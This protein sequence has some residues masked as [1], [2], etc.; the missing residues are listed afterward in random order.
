[1]IWRGDAGWRVVIAIPRFCM[2][3]SA[4]DPASMPAPDIASD[5]PRDLASVSDSPTAVPIPGTKSRAMPAPISTAP[6]TALDICC[7]FWAPGW[8]LLA[9][10]NSHSPRTLN[11]CDWS[12]HKTRFRRGYQLCAGEVDDTCDEVP[13]IVEND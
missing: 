7:S 5:V 3:V 13:T 4:T 1:M 12:S 11:C 6:A 8:Q 9:G 10:V 2:S